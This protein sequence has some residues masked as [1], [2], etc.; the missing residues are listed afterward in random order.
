MTPGLALLMHRYLCCM[1]DFG[2]VNV[3]DQLNEQ[4]ILLARSLEGFY[5]NRIHAEALRI[6]T[7]LRTLCHKTKRSTLLLEML[8]PDYLHLP[9]VDSARTFSGLSDEDVAAGAHPIL[10]VGFAYDPDFG[11]VPR[12]WLEGAPQVDLRRWWSGY[13]VVF[14]LNGTNRIF[15]RRELV[16][17]LANRGGGTHVDVFGLPLQHQALLKNS[18]AWA[19]RVDGTHSSYDLG[20][21]AIAQAGMEMAQ[22]LDGLST[23]RREGAP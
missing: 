5:V 14:T 2:Q 9:I 20:R 12:P 23:A 7:S 18:P 1:A 11:V 8:R 6:A 10:T 3:D 16:L 15:T 22:M 13:A 4:R 17:D 19:G 21:C